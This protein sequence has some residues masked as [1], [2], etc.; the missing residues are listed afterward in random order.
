MSMTPPE[1]SSEVTPPPKKT[2]MSGGAKVLIILGVVGGLLILLCCG[3]IVGFGIYVAGGASQDPDV[4]KEKTAEIAQ[5]DVP[6][7]LEPQMSFD[8][9]FPFYGRWMLW[10]VYVDEDSK[11]VLALFTL[12]Q[13]SAS[14]NPE[15]M[16]RAMDQSLQQQGM[17]KREGIRIQESS[18]KEVT[19]RG[20]TVTFTIAK[21]VG[22]E[23]NAPR[24]QATGVFQG[25]A[26]TVMLMLNADAEKYSEEQVVAMLESI[27]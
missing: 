18:K 9:K 12:P 22:E 7:G 5:I 17:G 4:V 10:V 14:A 6:E 1:M 2:G 16:R 25:E 26:G 11:S 19:I 24:I 3:G 20:Q 27:K 15:E 21:G 13:A 8:M 23:S